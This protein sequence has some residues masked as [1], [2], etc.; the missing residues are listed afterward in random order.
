MKSDKKSTL[1]CHVA[2]QTLT[3]IIIIIIVVTI[4]IIIILL[5]S[6]LSLLILLFINLRFFKI[7]YIYI[8]F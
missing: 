8:N 3:T 2:K 1:A 7:I 4:I 6:L 5:L